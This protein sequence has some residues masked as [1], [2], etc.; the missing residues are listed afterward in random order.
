MLRASENQPVV[1]TNCSRLAK[2][3]Q[4]QFI[5]LLLLQDL[6][7][8]RPLWT[9]C[10]DSCTEIS[11]ALRVSRLSKDAYTKIWKFLKCVTLPSKLSNRPSS[12]GPL[13]VKLAGSQANLVISLLLLKI[14]PGV[15]WYVKVSP[16][17]GTFSPLDRSLEIPYGRNYAL[18]SHYGHF[19]YELFADVSRS[20][21]KTVTLNQF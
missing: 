12:C 2:S 15:A 21:G 20:D 19:V 17:R 8:P 3:K 11:L 14:T 7:L 18:W 5:T 4:C 13:W 1:I 16:T 9:S 6:L 10:Q